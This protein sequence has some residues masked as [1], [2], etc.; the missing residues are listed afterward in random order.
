MTAKQHLLKAR[1]ELLKAS[2]KARQAGNPE[3]A[4]FYLIRAADIDLLI[5]KLAT[6]KVEVTL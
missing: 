5:S 1:A 2:T 6:R 3:A 4:A